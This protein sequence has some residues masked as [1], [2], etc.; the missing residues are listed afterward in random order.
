MDDWVEEFYEI[1]RLKDKKRTIPEMW[2]HLQENASKVGEALRRNE[3]GLA[4]REL[5]HVFC[6]LCSFV[7]KC[8]DEDQPAKY[9]NRAYLLKRK[10]W[11]IV[12]HKYPNACYRCGGSP[13]ECLKWGKDLERKDRQIKIAK[14]LEDMRKQK[15]TTPPT[16]DQL[17]E[18]FRLIYENTHYAIPIEYLGFHFLEEVGEVAR[19][20]L[21]LAPFEGKDLEKLTKPESKKLTE[22]QTKLAD[23]LADAFSWIACLLIKLD[24]F[25]ETMWNYYGLKRKRKKITLPEIVWNEYK[26]RRGDFLNCP[27]CK[28][29]PCRCKPLIGSKS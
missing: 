7:A 10:F 16:V 13:C 15:P 27:H 5:A 23:E 12:W 18:R 19:E 24:F 4:L 26:S 20:I 6:W 25:S 11:D 9:M 28:E 29:R 8:N 14:R 1:Y 17:V 2:L 3:Y 21:N 22:L